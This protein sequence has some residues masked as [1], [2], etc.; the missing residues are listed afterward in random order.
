VSERE[1]D[2]QRQRHP[3]RDR[4]RMQAKYLGYKA[5]NFW[6]KDSPDTGLE[7]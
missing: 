2:R 3:E 5:K 1:T 4:E 6:E 7:S